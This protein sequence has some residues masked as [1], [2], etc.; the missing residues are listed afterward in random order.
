MRIRMGKG[1]EK[2]NG[3]EN[4][5]YTYCKESRRTKTLVSSFRNGQGVEQ[6]QWLQE[7]PIGFNFLWLPKRRFHEKV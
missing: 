4:L 3:R 5:L 2:D 6:K 7:N 1:M